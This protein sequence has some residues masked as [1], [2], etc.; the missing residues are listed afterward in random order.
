MHFT[1]FTAVALLSTA[2][3]VACQDTTTASP[4]A[5]PKASDQ[6]PSSSSALPIGDRS[7]LV[8]QIH[9]H[10]LPL[11]PLAAPPAPITE[12]EKTNNPPHQLSSLLS[13]ATAQVTESAFAAEVSKIPEA[14]GKDLAADLASAAANIAWN[15]NKTSFAPWIAAAGTSGAVFSQITADAG[16]LIAQASPSATAT[17]GS[18]SGSSSS[19]AS[20]SASTGGVASQP[21]GAIMAVGAAAAGVLG[22]AAML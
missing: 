9:I 17:S 8:S 5:D 2:A 10:T 18:S 19:S 1:K 22:M 4:P 7:S 14:S 3:S 11:P 21:T 15:G 20:S 12:T 6:G 16:G 13:Q